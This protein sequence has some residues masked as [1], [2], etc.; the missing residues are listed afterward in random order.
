MEGEN[1]IGSHADLNDEGQTVS[2]PKIG[3]TLVGKDN[4]IHVVNA[5]SEDYISGYCKISGT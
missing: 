3:T 5:D 4:Q 2:I 1:R